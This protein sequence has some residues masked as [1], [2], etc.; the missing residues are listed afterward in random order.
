MKQ[1]SDLPKTHFVDCFTFLMP[2]EHSV[3]IWTLINESRIIKTDF[4]IGLSK[5]FKKPTFLTFYLNL[6]ILQSVAWERF[7]NFWLFANCGTVLW[8]FILIENTRWNVGFLLKRSC[9]P[10]F[11]FMTVLCIWELKI[12]QLYNFLIDL[13]PA[14]MTMP[15]L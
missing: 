10:Y 3:P 11:S 14:M 15:S 1:L 6:Q 12:L 8:S 7:L 13:T 5:T 2:R 4:G 9:L